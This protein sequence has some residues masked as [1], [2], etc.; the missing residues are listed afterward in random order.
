[1]GRLCRRSRRRGRG[2]GLGADDRIGSNFSIQKSTRQQGFLGV[3]AVVGGVPGDRGIDQR[4]SISVLDEVGAP[5]DRIDDGG[6][7]RAGGEQGGGA[8]QFVAQRCSDAHLCGR[9]VG[10]QVA[11][12]RD[13]GLRPGPAVDD[14]VGGAVVLVVAVA[15]HHFA[16]QRQPVRCQGGFTPGRGRDR[17]D[18]RLV[19]QFGECRPIQHIEH[20]FEY[21][22]GSDNR[23]KNFLSVD[24]PRFGRST[25]TPAPPWRPPRTGGRRCGVGH[26]VL[27]DL[28]QGV[29]QHPDDHP[30]PSPIGV[31]PGGLG[32]RVEAL[33]H[34]F[35]NVAVQLVPAVPQH[36]G[37]LVMRISGHRPGA[38][39]QPWFAVGGQHILVVQVVVDQH[40]GTGRV[41][42]EVG[43][44]RQG[45]LHQTCG[46]APVQALRR[47]RRLRSP[48][49]R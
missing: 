32:Q 37:D 45:L 28:P 29:V 15:G 31:E 21:S 13:L 14:L 17:G 46:R 3:G 48:R 4:Q 8:G 39:H 42:G 30:G 18:E 47:S 20:V 43:A 11:G 35:A 2:R 49:R 41:G 44:Q 16:D 10:V 36:R 5:G 19:A 9:G 6:R 23:R 24:N 33:P 40:A 38:D 7:D 22:R 25:F 12:R 26:R 27:G 34:A 1:M